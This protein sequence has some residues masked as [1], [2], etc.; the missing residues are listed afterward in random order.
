MD[1]LTKIEAAG[2]LGIT[3]RQLRNHVNAGRLRPIRREDG[4]EGIPTADLISLERRLG[5][6]S[7]MEHALRAPCECGASSLMLRFAGPE[8]ILRCPACRKERE[9]AAAERIRALHYL[10]ATAARLEA[11][12]FR[13]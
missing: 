6:P 12:M 9:A 4:T 2:R 10:L 13:E 7:E 1:A 3:L 5:R 8:P 11:A